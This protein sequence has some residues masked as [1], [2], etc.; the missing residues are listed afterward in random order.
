MTGRQMEDIKNANKT[1]GCEKYT[2]WDYQKIGDFREKMIN[3]CEDFAI[4]TSQAEAQ[5]IKRLKK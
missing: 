1:F 4:G 3:E 2:E 5:R